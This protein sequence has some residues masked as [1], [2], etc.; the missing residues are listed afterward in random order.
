MMKDFEDKLRDFT[1]NLA[2]FNIEW[3]EKWTKEGFSFSS[4]RLTTSHIEGKPV[5]TYGMIG[6]PSEEKERHPAIL[7]FHGGGQTASEANVLYHLRRGYVCMSFDWT[8]LREG[9]DPAVT[10]IYPEPF[11]VSLGNYPVQF[12]KGGMEGSYVFHGVKAARCCLRFLASFDEVDENAIGFYGISWGGY[13][14]WLVNATETIQKCAVPI[15][16]TGGLFLPGHSTAETWMECDEEALNAWRNL[17]P[18]NFVSEQKAPV[19]HINGTNDFFGGFD[20]ASQMLP[21]IN[22]PWLCDYTPNC[23][24]HFD[25]GSYR[26]IEQWFDYHLKKETTLLEPPALKVKRTGPKTLTV[27]SGGDSKSLTLWSSQGSARHALRCW[28]PRSDWREKDGSLLIDLEIKGDVWLYVRKRDEKTGATV[29]SRPL[30]VYSDIMEEV[31]RSGIVYD[32][33]CHHYGVG[34]NLG[35]E[36]GAAEKATKKLRHTSEGLELS[37][38]EGKVDGVVFFGPSRP[39]GQAP[40]GTTELAVELSGAKTLC[41]ECSVDAF[42]KEQESRIYKY[43]MDTIVAGVNKMPVS[44]FKNNLE[45]SLSDFSRVNSLKIACDMEEEGNVII[46]K[47][48]WG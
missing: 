16:G 6:F 10:T 38:T 7:H 31:P 9:R 13:M 23:N 1:P 2:D 42:E 17:E 30:R 35:T 40:E 3:I 32:G 22:Q 24:H 27:T 18:I 8:G 37:S 4:F 15:Y 29:S 44:G 11:D 39:G 19:L 41:V 25:S 45:E 36:I 26:L 20:V 47:I 21:L 12:M 14:S 33:G 48:S 34:L 5:R 28:E 46:R 43:Q